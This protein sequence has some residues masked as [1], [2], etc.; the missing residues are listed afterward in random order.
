MCSLPITSCYTG[1]RVYH[2]TVSQPDWF[3]C[4]FLL[5]TWHIGITQL[6]FIFLSEENCSIHSRKFSVSCE[7]VSWGS[8][9]LHRLEPESPSLKLL[10]SL[11]SR[12]C[13]HFRKFIVRTVFA[14]KFVKCAGFLCGCD[15]SPWVVSGWQHWSRTLLDFKRKDCWWC[16][17]VSL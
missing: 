16:S 7:E 2:E 1:D 15:F 14:Y 12:P 17:V 11:V 10:S 3:Q 4:G 13:F 5:L 9:L 8:L 6:L